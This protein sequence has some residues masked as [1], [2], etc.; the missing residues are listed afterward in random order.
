MVEHV[1]NVKNAKSLSV[2]QVQ[3]SENGEIIELNG[4]HDR[5][6]VDVQYIEAEKV[7]EVI[8]K[9]AENFNDAPVQIIPSA[10]QNCSQG[11]KAALPTAQSIKKMHNVDEKNKILP[12]CSKKFKP[13]SYLKCLYEQITS[14]QLSIRTNVY[15][16]MSI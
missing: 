14:E 1:G 4:N 5:H 13:Y 11:M 16:Q 8:R 6:V 9:K 12:T 10:V 7:K 15:K 3:K 2:V